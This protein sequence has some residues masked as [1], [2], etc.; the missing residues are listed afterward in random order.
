MRWRLGG[1]TAGT[2]VLAGVLLLTGCLPLATGDAGPFC[3]GATPP[4]HYQH[5]VI[6]VMENKTFSQVVGNPA[7][8]FQTSM[9]IACAST[10]HF[11]N[12]GSPSRPNYIAMT[13]GS[14]F[15]C[16][17]SDADPPGG[18]TPSSPSLFKQVIDS[19]GT[20]LSY[21]ESMTTNCQTTSSGE[22]AVKHNPW[23][24]FSAE[25]SL[26][27]QFNQP[28]P[29]SIDVANLPTLMYIAPNLCND[30]HDCSI[31]TGDQWLRSHI[32]PI[33]DSAAY[34][35]GSTAVI[36]TYDEYTNLPNMFASK[37]VQP[38]TV[39]ATNTNH[40][41]M[42]R[43]VEDMLGLSPLGQA[44]TATSLRSAMRL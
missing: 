3:S 40:Y 7:A 35:S 22:Y 14:T 32:R 42:L 26:C 44:A 15:G 17:G 33:L 38:G 34:A 37:S 20:V 43:T 28:M 18:C 12:E 11:A 6:V 21:A 41:G 27:Q 5:V 2:A 1:A 29:A 8:P 30:T 36:I 13:A 25:A 10:T 23:P 24:Y 31:A 16:L 39:L 19:G 9:A 4:A